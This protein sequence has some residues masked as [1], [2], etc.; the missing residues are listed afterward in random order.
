[1]RYNTCRTP[2]PGGTD[3]A[4]EMA[5]HPRSVSRVQERLARE[6]TVAEVDEEACSGCGVCV[7]LC[8]YEARTLDEKRQVA[9]VEE[10]LCQG[11]GACAS[12]CPSGATKHRNF[13]LTQYF[14]MVD[15]ILR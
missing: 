4:A 10:A 8:P 15:T 9:R 11:C 14:S 12:G 6:P 1:M 13:S 3:S 7:D 5:G 2:S